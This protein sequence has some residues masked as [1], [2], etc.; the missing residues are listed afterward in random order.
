MNGYIDKFLMK[1]GYS[2]PHKSQL[3]PHK[4][5]EATY[6]SKEQLT[7][8]EYNSPLLEKEGNR[9][10]Q[11]IVWAL[12]Y[13]ERAV[14]N[15]LLV[16]LSAIDAQQAATTEHTNETMNQLPDYSATCPANGILYYSRNMVL[17]CLWVILCQS[18]CVEARDLSW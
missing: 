6:G 4:H 10:I 8:E 1:Y 2:R 17:T 7:P 9:R 15:K 16:G 13:Y 14:D 18:G 5:R 12:L 3:S 11:G